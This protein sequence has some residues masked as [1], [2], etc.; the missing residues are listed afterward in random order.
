M[1]W[2]TKYETSR[3]AICRWITSQDPIA[4]K[5]FV[6][7]HGSSMAEDIDGAPVFMSSERVPTAL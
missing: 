3:F 5:S 1:G 2:R 6:N 4:L 7:S